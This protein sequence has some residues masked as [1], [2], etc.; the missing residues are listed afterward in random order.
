MDILIL[1]S[2]LDSNKTEFY[3]FLFDDMVLLTKQPKKTKVSSL[4]YV[5]SFL[6]TIIMQFSLR[7]FD[8]PIL[9]LQYLY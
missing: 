8:M 9:L 5:I 6:G 2:I 3:V 7:S 4:I 1:Y